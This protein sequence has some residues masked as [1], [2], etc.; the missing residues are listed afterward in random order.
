MMQANIKLSVIRIFLICMAIL[1]LSAPAMQKAFS[2]GFPEPKG[3]ITA[4][5]SS[6]AING[7]G[8]K[9]AAYIYYESCQADVNYSNTSKAECDAKGGVYQQ[10]PYTYNGFNNFKFSTTAGTLSN[11]SVKADANGNV[12]T[13]LTSGSAGQ[14]TVTLTWWPDLGSGPV[15]D[16]KIA[17]KTA[18]F[19]VPTAPAP[20]SKPKTSAPAPITV[21]PK[22]STPALASILVKGSAV[23]VDQP[24]MVKEDEPLVLSGKTVPNGIVT[25]YIF[26][27]PKKAEVVADKDGN[28]TYEISGL[29]PDEHRVEMEVTDPAT[30]LTSDRA[31]VLA[32][33]VEAAEKP[34]IMETQP[35]LA[36]NDKSGNP[37]ILM[38]SLAA[39]VLAVG[40]GVFFAKK[41]HRG[42]FKKQEA[43]ISLLAKEAQEDKPE[44]V[45]TSDS[46]EES[47]KTHEQ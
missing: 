8:I 44:N 34:A 27:D 11:T 3:G 5:A 17:T 46:S 2:A 35:Q 36:A 12:S 37:I 4:S 45:I 28:W 29:P 38:G 43:S 30:K 31:Q 18:S 9:L 32:F 26:S 7:A 39:V 19:A 20:V 42:P 23:A 47:N 25:L 15:E 13:T 33:T 6:A 21:T 16:S 10:T 22:P 40:A 41:K 1:L 24:V 14:A